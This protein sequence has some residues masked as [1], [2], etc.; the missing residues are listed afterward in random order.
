MILKDGSEYKGILIKITNDEIFFEINGQE[1]VFLK[2]NI[3]RL[4]LNKNR[5]YEDVDNI[6]KINDK[7]IS[8]VWI[9][10]KKWNKS[11][12]F[13]IV[14]LLDKTTYDFIDKNKYKVNIKKAIKI[15]KEEGK[16]YSTQVINYFKNNRAELLYAI[17]VGPDGKVTAI[18]EEAI[19]DEP[20]NNEYS[21]YDL[22]RRV[23]FGLKDVDVGSLIIW[24]AEIDEYNEPLK[25]PFF[26]EKELV[27]NE[28]IEKQVIKISYPE[29]LKINYFIYNGLINIEKPAIKEEKENRINILT[30]E[31]NNVNA[32]INDE[33]NPPNDSILKPK[34]YAGIANDW[35]KLGNLYFN[36]YFD[37]NLSI[38]FIDFTKNLVKDEKDNENKLFKIYDFIN[39]KINKVDIPLQDYFQEPNNDD[40]LMSLTS[41]N[42]LDKSYL[43]ARMAKA[44]GINSDFYFYRSNLKNDLIDSTP[45]IRQFDSCICRVDLNNKNFY[46]SF[47]DKNFNF[48]QRPYITSDAWSLMI[49]K[50]SKI[51]K[52][53]KLSNDYNNYQ[54]RY[55]CILNEDNSLEITKTTSFNGEYQRPWRDKRFLSKDEL[56]I[57][58]KKRLSLISNNA[59]LV[60]YNFLNNLSDLDKP[61]IFEEE[62]FVKDYAYT[63][64]DKIKLFKIPELRIRANTVSRQARTLPYYMGI[65]GE[66]EYIF[67]IKIPENY[68]VKSLPES[69]ES[70][71][72]NFN[73]NAKFSVNKNVISIVLS[74]NNSQELL[75]TKQYP[76]YKKAIEDLAKITN[77]W[78]ILEKAL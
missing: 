25:D 70:N 76:L 23:K 33:P 55:D 67:N 1:K 77:E 10:S 26:I 38:K 72:E 44:L 62:I 8:N 45:A 43:F 6:T 69:I 11:K 51:L 28:P 36:T 5:L 20:V 73:F 21:Q 65:I 59:N 16:D 54:Y 2:T 46:I 56:D 75:S 30:V 35:E 78:I 50:N 64:G 29:D 74:Q 37:K 9:Q 40:K 4:Q 42:V 13:R 53:D 41:L 31:Q 57:F 12:N 22:L 63:S 68:I 18:D 60:S 15:L 19:N 47:E 7:E 49:S 61:V 48:G 58:M 66:K 32:F 39:T 24:E 71:N 17:T 3:N 27:A 52:L 14:T 34:F